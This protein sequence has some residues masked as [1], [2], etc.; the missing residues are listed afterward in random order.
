MMDTNAITIIARQ[1][2]VINIRNR[3]TLVFAGVFGILVLAISYFGLV[4]AGAV[5]FQGFA[6]TSASLLNMVLY[7][8][9]LV[10]LTMGTLSFTSEKSAGELL[11]AQPVTRGEILLGKFMGLFASIFTATL[12]GFGLAG[13]IIA[14]EAGTEGSWRYPWFVG[15]SLLLALVFLSLSAFISALCGRKSKALGVALFVWFFFVLFYDLL[16]IGGTFLLKEQT[17]NTL[18][19]GS[20]FGNPVDMVRIASLMTLNGKNIFGAGGAALLKFLGGEGLSIALLL[21]ALS[22]WVVAPLLFAQRL[23]RR[24]DI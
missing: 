7:I 17:A 18:I 12:V 10:A 22:V 8:V 11:F 6:R 23:L 24:Q 16:V 1:E 9:P 4:T 19:F 13:I 14:A 2:L 20:L 3:W 15:F 5:G 21:V